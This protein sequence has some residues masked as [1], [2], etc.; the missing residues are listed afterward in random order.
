MTTARW[1]TMREVKHLTR[2][3]VIFPNV[4]GSYIPNYDSV[5]EGR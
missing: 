2:P 5:L 4:V 1:L 3:Q